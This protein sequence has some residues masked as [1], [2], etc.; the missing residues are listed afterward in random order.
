MA[1][2]SARQRIIIFNERIKMFAGSL[3]ALGVATIVLSLVRPLLDDTSEPSYSGV[4]IGIGALLLAWALLRDLQE[5]P[6]RSS[7]K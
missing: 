1:D 5:E 3:N 6:E 4:V 7:E 2:P